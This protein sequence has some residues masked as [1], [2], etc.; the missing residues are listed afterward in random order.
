MRLSFPLFG[1]AQPGRTA[2][3]LVVG[4]GNPGARYID[5]RHNVGFQAVDRLAV[6][7]DL[8]FDERHDRAVLARG[9]VDGVRVALVKPQTYMNLSGPAVRGVARFYKVAVAQILVVYD[10]LDL[11]L[12]VL[13]LRQQGGAGGHRGV[14]SL[15]DALDS[16]EFP[17]VRIGI[18][19][20]DGSMPPEAYVLQD[21]DA[22]QRAVIEVAIDRAVA[23]IRTALR[24]GF[25]AAMNQ[26]NPT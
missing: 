17:R 14:M 24:E 15:I 7:V 4:L 8:R 23:A 20:P 5:N 1:R 19:R 25:P 21:F 6:A 13:R 22:G 18:G 11:P 3:W 10:D 16:Q 9:D 2:S 12:G 26:F